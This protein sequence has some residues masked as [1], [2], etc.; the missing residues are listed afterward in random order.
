MSIIL[1]ALKKAQSSKNTPKQNETIPP[2]EPNGPLK[3]NG[4][5]AGPSRAP[6]QDTR[7][8]GNDLFNTMA[9]D[10]VKTSL[11]KPMAPE[12]ST[13]M[14]GFIK[15][16][17][18]VFEKI[19]Q[20]SFFK[21]KA[22]MFNPKQ[23]VK[24]TD[25]Q[26]DNKKRVIMLA[27]IA[28]LGLAVVV[29]HSFGPD[30]NEQVAIPMPKK[31]VMPKSENKE[32][33]PETNIKNQEL[34]EKVAR[35]KEEA[36]GYFVEKK[37]D[38]SMYVYKQLIEIVPTE[39]EHYN[40]YGLSLKKMGKT[41]D[42]TQAYNTALALKTDYPEALNNLAV[43]EMSEKKYNDARRRLEQAIQLKPDYLDPH[44]HLAICLEKT[45]D[46]D[47]AKQYYQSFL[48]MS[49]GKIDRKIRLQIENRLAK[50]DEENQ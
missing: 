49:E 40:N 15:E 9:A 34:L 3:T 11:T 27:V 38:R 22:G 30:A 2:T 24:S 6:K 32:I 50:I 14:A 47:A 19:K 4:T 43:V 17:M 23:T 37:Y 16:P 10:T 41:K 21:P 1:D 33:K 39:A 20:G 31:A 7:P 42:A 36:A 5:D 48:A 29:Y 44:L 12:S 46:V 18:K 45:G 26:Q 35:L 28:V 13:T 25:P 8:A